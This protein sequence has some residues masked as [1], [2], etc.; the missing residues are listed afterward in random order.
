MIEEGIMLDR[1]VVREFLN[2]E[3]REMEIPDDILKEEI[4]ETFYQ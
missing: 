2:K 3:L 1:K 4:V